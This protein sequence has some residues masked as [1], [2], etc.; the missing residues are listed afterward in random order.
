MP[1][2]VSQSAAASFHRTHFSNWKHKPSLTCRDGDRQ[3]HETWDCGWYFGLCFDQHSQEPKWNSIFN[4]LA[5]NGKVFIS[6]C[7]TNKNVYQ[8]VSIKRC[9]SECHPFSLSLSLI[10]F[11]SNAWQVKK[12]AW[13]DAF[14]GINRLNIFISVDLIDSLIETF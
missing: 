9:H 11:I 3:R 5:A 8:S 6:M 7:E 12:S 4:S 10:H 13:F 2:N 14:I 1:C